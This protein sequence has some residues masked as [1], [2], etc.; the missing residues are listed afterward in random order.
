MKRAPVKSAYR[1]PKIARGKSGLETSFAILWSQ[2]PRCRK[3][4]AAAE[5]RF[6]PPRKWRF[7]FA[8][9]AVMVAVELEGGTYSGRKSRHTTATGHQGD[10][11][12]YNAAAIAGWCVLRY[13]AQDMQR[14]PLQVFDEILSAI[15]RRTSV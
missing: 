12:K 14:R 4:P 9:P 15:E 5:H 3:F 1:R 13:T 7:D 6:Q 8:W 10:C 11:E 2:H